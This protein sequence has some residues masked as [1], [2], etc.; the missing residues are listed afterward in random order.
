MTSSSAPQVNTPVTPAA[1]PADSKQRVST[2]MKTLQDEICQRLEE[3]DGG[4]NF[5]EDSWERPQGGGGRSRVIKAGNLF[6]QGGVN[7]SEVWGS[8]LP[9][10]ILV[11]RPEAA[12]HGFYATGTSMVL[13]P[14]NPYIPTVHLNYRYFEAGP[15]WWFGGGIDLTPYYPFREDASQFHQTIKAACDRHNPEYYNVFKPWCDEYFFLKHRQEPR[16]VGGIFFDYQDGRG[17]L[18]RGP[19]PQGIAATKSNEIGEVAPRSWEQLFAFVQECGRSFIPA[20]EPIVQKRRD[21]EYGDRQRDF[22]LYRRG[23][24]VEFNLIY[25]RG[26]IFGLQTNGRT[27]SILMSLPPLVRW[28][29][30]FAPEANTP[31][32]ELYDLFLKPQDWANWTPGKF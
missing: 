3:L 32:S 21:M 9:P 4:Q 10:S 20:Y 26:T 22:Q 14:R 2:F 12:G 5:L 30:S 13:H 11:Q 17:S 28:E 1:P 25:D 7:F 23:R 19:D 24:Y 18:Y 15:V 29:Y 8:D 16:G 31:E 6:E 27:E